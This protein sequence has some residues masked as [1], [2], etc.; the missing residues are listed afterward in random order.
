[1]SRRSLFAIAVVVAA[2]VWFVVA[3]DQRVDGEPAATTPPAATA[4]ELEGPW[5]VARVIDG[6][7]IGV[8]VEGEWRLVRLIGVDA[9]EI[10][11][12]YTTAEAGG[13]EAKRY[14]ESLL[15]GRS[16]YLERDRLQGRKDRFGRELAYVY[17]EPDRLLINEALICSGHARAY[18]R[19]RSRMRDRLI[20]CEQN[21]REKGFGLWRPADD[22]SE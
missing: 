1:M 12:P 18:R 19:F 2:V 22:P 21:A 3:G 7:T 13:E 10:A 16:V 15:A 11:G 20:E 14:V 4:R 6:D 17:R 5:P 8:T 9:P